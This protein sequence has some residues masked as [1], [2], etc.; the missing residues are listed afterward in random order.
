MYVKS[1]NHGP[2]TPPC[3]FGFSRVNDSRALIY[4]LLIQHYVAITSVDVTTGHN[5]EHVST[6]AWKPRLVAH[7][8]A[9]RI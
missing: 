4:M 9:Y 1:A 3:Q 5:Q 8:A 2:I 6:Y 7:K